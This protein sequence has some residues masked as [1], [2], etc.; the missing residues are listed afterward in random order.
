MIFLNPL[1]DQPVVTFNDLSAKCCPVLSS[2]FYRRSIQN[3]LTN[4]WAKYWEFRIPCLYSLYEIPSFWSL[5]SLN[6]FI[7]YC[8]KSSCASAN[9]LFSGNITMGGGIW[10][11]HIVSVV[12][13]CVFVMGSRH[14]ELQLWDAFCYGHLI[15][16]LFSEDLGL[17]LLLPQPCSLWINWVKHPSEFWSSDADWAQTGAMRS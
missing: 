14:L 9:L 2:L 6:I 16:H 8:L 12:H 11:R 10:R 4:Y 13:A 17:Y 5:K 7:V 3:G 1:L 15:L